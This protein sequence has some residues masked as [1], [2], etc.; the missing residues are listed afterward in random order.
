[1]MTFAREQERLSTK[2]SQ[3]HE[4]YAYIVLVDL[5]E[6]VDIYFEQMKKRRSR[7]REGRS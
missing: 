1:M 6:P 3:K 7:M 4:N 2:K 5:K